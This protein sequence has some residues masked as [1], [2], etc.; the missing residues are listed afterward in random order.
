MGS[1]PQVLRC[2]GHIDGRGSKATIPVKYPIQLKPGVFSEVALQRYDFV[3]DALA[4]VCSLMKCGREQ[5]PC[6][7]AH[8]TLPPSRC[9]RQGTASPH[10]ASSAISRKPCPCQLN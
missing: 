3:M 9:Q 2:F 7:R 6:S 4:K 5:C 10:Q 8:D 1:L